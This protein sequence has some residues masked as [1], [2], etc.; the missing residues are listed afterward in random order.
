MH[1]L[2][3]VDTFPEGHAPF[4]EWCRRRALQYPAQYIDHVSNF[5]PREIRFYDFVIPEKLEKQIVGDLK[6]FGR[7][8]NMAQVEALAKKMKWFTPLKPVSDVPPK[9]W[10]QLRP[11]TINGY[12]MQ[13]VHIALL[14]KIED[15]YWKKGHEKGVEMI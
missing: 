12:P 13:H 3:M 10:F 11:N 4:L 8:R 9:K 2:G 1:I 14:G 5:M 7:N 15:S 6:A